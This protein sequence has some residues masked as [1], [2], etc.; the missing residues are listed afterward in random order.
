MP[1]EMLPLFSI[2]FNGDL[3][4]KPVLQLIFEQLYEI[5]FREFCFVVG[6]GKRS[7]ED[8]FTPDYRYIELLKRRG[9]KNLAKELEEF[10]NR[11]E[12]SVIAWINQP[13][14]KGFGDAVLKA[15]PF[16]GSEPFL[17]HAGDTYII[18]QGISH[19]RRLLHVHEAH[20]PSATLTLKEVHDPK[21]L[22]G[23]AEVNAY[24]SVIRVLRVVEKPE[25]PPSNLAIMPIYVFEPEIFGAIKETGPGVGGEIQ[26]T[27]AIQKLID[28]QKPVEAIKLRGDEVRLDVGTPET[29]WEALA[30]SYKHAKGGLNVEIP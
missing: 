22:Y 1:K 27:D 25:K 2:G 23:C 4:L 13:E 18:S 26:L 14:P 21:K 29:Y 7:I 6:R 11:V 12:S 20:G 3:S 5:G 30:I 19:I 16:V 10:Y 8:H 24:G 17:V 9:E 28:V 15:E